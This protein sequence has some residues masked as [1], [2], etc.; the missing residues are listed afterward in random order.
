M[1]LQF[2]VVD[3]VAFSIG[4]VDVRWYGLAYLAGILLGWM[5]GLMLA[6]RVN[7]PP[8]AVDVDDFM[9]WAVVGIIAGGR[10]GYILFYNFSYYIDHP[11]EAFKIWEGGMSFHGGLSGVLIAMIIFTARRHIPFLR[12]SDIICAAAPIGLFFGRM[13]NFVNAELYGRASDLP[14][15]VIFPGSD[16]EPR[17]PSQIYEALLEGG[18]L[19]IILFVCMRI[20]AIRNR[21]G[22]VSGAFVAGYG[23][24]RALIELVREPDAHIGFVFYHFSMGQLLSFPMIVIGLSVICFAVYRG[25]RSLASKLA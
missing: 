3:P 16:G 6:R 12:M 4:F 13:A 7:D 8:H 2:P 5:Y 19:F 15:A 21:P 23:L 1:A 20:E 24:F 18:L 14:W 25:E 11:L 17:H 9:S 10:L 22:I